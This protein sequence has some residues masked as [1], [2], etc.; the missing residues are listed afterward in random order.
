MKFRRD[1]PVDP[2]LESEVKLLT[3]FDTVRNNIRMKVIAGGSQ[4]TPE[5]GMEEIRKEWNR[6]GGEAVEKEMTEWYQKNN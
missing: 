4:Y 1:L 6:L 5:W 3:E 2:Q